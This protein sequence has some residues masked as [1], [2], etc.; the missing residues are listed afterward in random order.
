MKMFSKNKTGLTLV[1]FPL[2]PLTFTY[3]CWFESQI[4]EFFM[5]RE[6]QLIFQERDKRLE[7]TDGRPDIP[8][9][10]LRLES[11]V[12][13]VVDPGHQVLV[14]RVEHS[15]THGPVLPGTTAK[16]KR[17]IFTLCQLKLETQT[18]FASQLLIFFALD[19]IYNLD[20]N[21]QSSVIKG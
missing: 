15:S 12:L 10:V 13:R 21:L 1:I 6:L 19:I 8:S 17:I 7:P 3:V 14:L 5:P 2:S 4:S 16:I 9:P 20:I 18:L 11:E